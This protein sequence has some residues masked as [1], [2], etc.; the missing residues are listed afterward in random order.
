MQSS[1]PSTWQTQSLGKGVRHLEPRWQMVPSG[2]G[3]PWEE[4]AALLSL[5][6]L[7]HPAARTNKST[8]ERGI[9]SRGD[10]TGRAV[11]SG[12]ALARVGQLAARIRLYTHTPS[13]IVATVTPTAIQPSD[14][15]R[16]SASKSR[17]PK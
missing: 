4:L 17:C 14:D 6:V 16:L 8:M 7:A 9:G 12:A 15:T 2:R 3:Q 10:R 13:A 1:T 11:A 5:T